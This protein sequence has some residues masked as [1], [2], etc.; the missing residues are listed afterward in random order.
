ME[1]INEQFYQS[2]KNFFKNRK[3][4]V[5]RVFSHGPTKEPY[6]RH[7]NLDFNPENYKCKLIYINTM[8]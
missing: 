5:S 2:K 7:L 3:K 4:T 6:L 1:T 8:I